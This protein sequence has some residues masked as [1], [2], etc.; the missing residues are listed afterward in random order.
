MTDPTMKHIT[1]QPQSY[2]S[3]PGLVSDDI[4]VT[5]GRHNG[6]THL[7]YHPEYILEKGFAALEGKLDHWVLFAVQHSTVIDTHGGSGAERARMKIEL[8]IG[9]P[10]TL[11][12]VRGVWMLANRDQRKLEGD[13]Y[14]LVPYQDSH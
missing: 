2:T 6:S 7:V 1:L 10:F 14:K 5:G 12:H 13:G 8:A 9:E 4:R 3:H 11:A